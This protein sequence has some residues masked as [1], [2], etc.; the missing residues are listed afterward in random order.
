MSTKKGALASADQDSL[1]ALLKLDSE[2]IL[3]GLPDGIQA[4]YTFSPEDWR[5]DC[6]RVIL[7][8][9]ATGRTFTV[10]TLRQRGVL[11]PDKHVRWG[12]VFSI[13]R[14]RKAIEQVGVHLHQTAGGGTSAMREWRGA[15]VL[16]D[17]SLP[18]SGGDA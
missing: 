7:E 4:A 6:E 15:P 1:N 9:A 10:D 14:K 17:A 3:T 13:M 11:E 5:A 8:L 2:A 12:S 16:T 18:T